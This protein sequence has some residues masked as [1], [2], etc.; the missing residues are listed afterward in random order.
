MTMMLLVFF[1]TLVELDSVLH[2]F[3]GSKMQ[4][5]SK[6]QKISGNA[7]AKPH[8]A[9]EALIRNNSSNKPESEINGG[10]SHNGPSS[11]LR[12]NKRKYGAVNKFNQG[13]ETELQSYKEGGI[14]GTGV[15]PNNDELQNENHPR[16]LPEAERSS[17]NGP[18]TIRIWKG[19]FEVLNIEL[20]NI[21]PRARICNICEGFRAYPPARV[22]RKAYEFSE[23]IDGVMQFKLHPRRLD[24][25]FF[26]WGVY[27]E[28]VSQGNETTSEA[29]DSRHSKG[30][31][32]KE[33][34]MDVG[35]GQNR[36][37]DRIRN[38]MQRKCKLIS[39]LGVLGRGKTEL[40]VDF[41]PLSPIE[42]KKDIL[43]R[44]K[45]VSKGSADRSAKQKAN[46]LALAHYLETDLADMSD[47]GD[48]RVE[49]R[50]A[51]QAPHQKELRDTQQTIPPGQREEC[52]R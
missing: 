52:T 37:M 36:K 41:A 22:S 11:P 40:I 12:D 51:T 29:H 45:G 23:Q 28:S 50:S 17:L 6:A 30:K 39:S 10:L 24:G 21:E 25:S 16:S 38:L 47:E 48:Q 27:R 9:E 8:H 13:V 5:P 7:K 49:S 19:R 26:M 31:G 46:D 1:S 43:Q 42:G 14:R 33:T 32:K 15:G 3:P 18:A 44:A 34:S 20:L 4:P 35:D 2:N